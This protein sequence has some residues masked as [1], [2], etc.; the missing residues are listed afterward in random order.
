MAEVSQA[1]DDRGVLSRFAAQV[2]RARFRWPAMRV[3]LVTASGSHRGRSVAPA[4]PL[5]G[6]LVPARGWSWR[7][8]AVIKD[9]AGTPRLPRGTSA[10]RE[11]RGSHLV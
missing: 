2:D 9:F 6:T 3:K 11:A 10:T 5:V 4:V 7:L 1:G 8:Q